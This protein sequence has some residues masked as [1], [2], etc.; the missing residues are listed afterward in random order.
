MT[1]VSSGPGSLVV[2]GDTLLDRDLVGTATRLCP[3]APAPVLEDV[4][5]YARPGG[6]G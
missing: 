4:A 5:D 2:V 6:A 3:D 1:S